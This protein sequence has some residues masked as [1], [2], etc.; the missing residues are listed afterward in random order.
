VRHKFVSE[1]REESK[2]VEVTASAS[3]SVDGKAVDR[4]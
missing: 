2:A 3:V 4:N 1:A